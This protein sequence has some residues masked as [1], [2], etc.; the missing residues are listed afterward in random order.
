MSLNATFHMSHTQLWFTNSFSIFSLLRM[1]NAQC[2]MPNAKCPMPKVMWADLKRGTT[3]YQTGKP[4]KGEFHKAGW[5]LVVICSQA[6]PDQDS[7]LFN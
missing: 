3:K 5:N 4:A 1:P 6:F 7:C 2:Q